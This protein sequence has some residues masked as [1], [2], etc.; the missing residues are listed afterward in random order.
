MVTVCVGA[1]GK[2]AHDYLAKATLDVGHGDP[3]KYGSG[4]GAGAETYE[5]FN[6]NCCNTEFTF[7]GVATMTEL[8]THSLGKPGTCSEDPGSAM[9][10]GHELPMEL[11]Y[12]SMATLRQLMTPTLC[13][14]VVAP[15]VRSRPVPSRNDLPHS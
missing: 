8:G 15:T 13:L 14:P 6:P 2:D 1:T 3:H 5:E 11:L 4:Y 10:D 12:E 7:V 9:E